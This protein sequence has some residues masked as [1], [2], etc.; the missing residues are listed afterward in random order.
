MERKKMQNSD[1]FIFLR[2]MRY[3]RLCVS[4]PYSE[5][6]GRARARRLFIII[7]LKSRYPVLFN[8]NIR[9]RDT[10]FILISAARFART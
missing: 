6:A 5:V 7:R 8:V 3:T 1:W 10:P 2:I 4:A 9:Y